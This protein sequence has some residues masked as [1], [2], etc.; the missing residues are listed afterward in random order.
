MEFH[1]LIHLFPGERT[2]LIENKAGF[3][4]YLADNNR[5]NQLKEIVPFKT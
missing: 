1:P 2:Y 3:S 4:S 5:E